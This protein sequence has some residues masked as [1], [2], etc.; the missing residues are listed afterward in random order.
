MN[1]HIPKKLLLFASIKS[2]LKMTKN[3]FCFLLKCLFLFLKYLNFCPDFFGYVKSDLMTKLR[4]Q[5]VLR[6]RL[7]YRWI[8]I[9]K[10][11]KF[12]FYDMPN[13]VV[14]VSKCPSADYLLLPHMNPF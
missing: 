8:N 4:S 7:G 3:V 9:L 1:S 14:Q 11:Y 13:R 5:N 10:C 2:P 12:C 6:H